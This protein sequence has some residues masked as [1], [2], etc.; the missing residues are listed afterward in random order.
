MNI[1]SNNEFQKN[2]AL[3]GDDL[4]TSPYYLVTNTSKTLKIFNGLPFNLTYYVRDIF[5]KEIMYK[6]NSKLPKVEIFLNDSNSFLITHYPQNSIEV[7]TYANA[8]FNSIKITGDGH[9]NFSLV[10]VL[11]DWNFNFVNNTL[12]VELI[13]CPLGYYY[14][15]SVCLKCNSESYTFNEY[16]KLFNF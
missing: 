10:S 4:T 14:Q 11:T 15:S 6:Q 3:Y 13:G 9:Q 16:C 2:S 1:T 8:T 12:Q 7:N 5:N